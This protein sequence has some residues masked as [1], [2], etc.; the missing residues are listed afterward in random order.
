MIVRCG[1]GLG[2]RVAAM[3]NGLSRAV[4]I[5]FIW[6]V[7]QHCPAD[8]SDLFPDGIPG[9]TF[10]TEAPPAM[11][12]QWDGAW[13]YDW[14]AAGSRQ[15]ANLAYRTIMHS[16]VG[17]A[18]SYAPRTAVVGRFYRNPSGDPETLAK[19]AVRAVKAA[20]GERRAFLLCDRFSASVA[21]YLIEADVTPVV[22]LCGELHSDLAR[23][24]GDLIRY[25]SDW[26]TVLS[27]RRIVALD[28]PASALHPARA[29][30][31]RIDYAG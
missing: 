25:A 1:M 13:C 18:P 20:K 29:A 21:A 24:R 10:V 31:I 30:G 28:G 8:H 9:V 3:A 5:R 16:M 19:A 12:T 22:S 27:A 2:N 23:S 6:R 11:A 7:N 26:K 14:H 15:A 17:T 4:E